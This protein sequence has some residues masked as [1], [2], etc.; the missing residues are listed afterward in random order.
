MVVIARQII[1]IEHY[2]KMNTYFYFSET[3]SLIERKLYV[4]NINHDLSVRASGLEIQNGQHR[5]IS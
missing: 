4:D 5:S 3:K 1:N 2:V